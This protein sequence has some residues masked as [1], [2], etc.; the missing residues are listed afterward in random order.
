MTSN[1]TNFR[2]KRT[3]PQKTPKGERSTE[4]EG[5]NTNILIAKINNNRPSTRT[6]SRKNFPLVLFDRSLSL[7]TER[8]AR[9]T[10]PR[11][12]RT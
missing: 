6:L 10:I 5:K 3:P 1:P 4:E 8:D 11:E 7:K 2:P 9:P 12:R